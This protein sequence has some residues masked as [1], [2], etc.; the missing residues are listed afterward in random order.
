MLLGGSILA[1]ALLCCSNTNKMSILMQH[2]THR[3]KYRERERE[4]ERECVCVCVCVCV[5]ATYISAI[6][7]LDHLGIARNHV[8]AIRVELDVDDRLIVSVILD[9]QRVR[10]SQIVH[11][12][13]TTSRTQRNTKAIVVIAQCRDGVV[14]ENMAGRRSGRKCGQHVFGNIQRSHLLPTA[15]IPAL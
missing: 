7:N 2:V 4:R 8:L 3:D 9:K 12:N 10:R 11:Q 13:M 15:W 14:V 5:C 1:N 6:P